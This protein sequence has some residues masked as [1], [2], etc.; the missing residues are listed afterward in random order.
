VLAELRGLLLDALYPFLKW[1][2][3]KHLPFTHKAVTGKQYYEVLPLLKSGHIFVTKIRGELTS[4]IIPGFWSHAAI[5]TPQVVGNINEFVTEAEDPGVVRTDLVSF[6]TS[7]D[8]FMVLEPIGT[9]DYVMELA[10]DLAHRALGEP[11]DYKLQVT[12]CDPI[13]KA[14]YCSGLVWWAYDKACK[15]FKFPSTFIAKK[16]L[17]VFTVSPDDIAKSGRFRIIYDS[18]GR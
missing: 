8:A 9:P 1:A 14:F 6:L 15:E 2:S 7:K 12:F 17:G 10:A 4:V 11:Y 18:R 16:Q 13:P 3:G 5:Y